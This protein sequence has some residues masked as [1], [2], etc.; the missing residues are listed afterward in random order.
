MLAILGAGSEDIVYSGDATQDKA[1]FVGFA[2]DYGV[3]HRFRNL[4]DGSELLITGA[5]NKS[6]PL[7]LKKNGAGQWYFDVQA[8]KNE[9]LARRIGSDETAATSANRTMVL[10]ST[11]K[12]SSVMKANRM[13]CT[14][15]LLRDSPRARSD[16]WWPL[17]RAKD[18]R[19]SRNSISLFTGTTSP[20]WTSRE[21]MRRVERR[22]ISLTGR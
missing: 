19:F 4:S 15:P 14:G 12:N 21:Q 10:S 8:G 7:P 16:P 6:F 11:L 1:A 13:D 18:I 5:D 9:I 17:P 2:S 3:M 20:C 22:T